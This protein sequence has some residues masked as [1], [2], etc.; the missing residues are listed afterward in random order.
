MFDVCKEPKIATQPNTPTFHTPRAG[1]KRK[2][3]S[4]WRRLIIAKNPWA[5]DTARVDRM[6]RSLE[7]LLLSSETG[8]ILVDGSMTPLGRFNASL[9]EAWKTVTTQDAIGGPCPIRA[10]TYAALPEN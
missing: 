8:S 6:Q 1:S 5:R 3:W 4:E 7:A 10:A 9:G 2:L